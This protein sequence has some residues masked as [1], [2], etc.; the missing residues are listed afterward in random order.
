MSGG[1]V[2]S[3]GFEH[4]GPETP[5]EPFAY[6]SQ[7]GGSRAK[8]RSPLGL[9][10][11]AVFLIACGVAIFAVMALS[12]APPQRG[13]AVAA[14]IVVLLMFGGLGVAAL[15]MGV[16]RLRWKNQYVRITGKQPWS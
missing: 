16:K 2:P 10:F 15:I 4:P 11:F 3:G 9:I 13:G 12:S 8:I 6:L 1:F 5:R 7:P 14:G